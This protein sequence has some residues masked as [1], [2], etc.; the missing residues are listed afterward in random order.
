M[1]EPSTERLV[2]LDLLRGLAALAIVTRHF[3]WP[4]DVIA[5]LPRDY[6]AV[7]LFFVLSGFVLARAWWPSLSSGRGAR[8]FLI[9]RLVRLY[10]LYLLATLLAAGVAVANGAAP[11]TWIATLGANLLFLPGQ[12]DSGFGPNLFPF[13]YPAWSLLWELLA[14]LL[15]ALIAFRLRGPLLPAILIVGGLL[16]ALTAQQVGSLDAGARWSDAAGGGCRV[17]YGFFAGVALFLLHDRLRPRVAVPDWVLG[18]ALLAAFAP[19]TALVFGAAYDFLIAALFFPLLVL[20]GANARTTTLSRRIGAGL[21]GLS[22]AVYVLHQPVLQVATWLIPANR[23]GASGPGGL[24]A[25]VLV[26]LIVAW[27]ATRW[28]DTP[29]RLWLKRRRSRHSADLAGAFVDAAPAG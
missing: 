3:P 13:V 12:P 24:A 25:L 27:M 20:L 26:T 2:A 28:I 21:G 15:L 23:L 9:Q 16:L 5:F 6:L 19:G 22:Y 7:D 14:N 10:P 18:L 4:G 8:G 29:V 17:L 1:N 11:G